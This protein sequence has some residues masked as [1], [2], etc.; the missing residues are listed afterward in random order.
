V[1]RLAV[2]GLI[3]IYL[4]GALGLQLQMQFCCGHL[5]AVNL[6]PEA[7]CTKDSACCNHQQCCS[8]ILIDS[9]VDEAHF[10]S[11]FSVSVDNH[12]LPISKTGVQRVVHG[13]G[14]TIHLSARSYN[15]PPPKT[16]AQLLALH[17]DWQFD[18]EC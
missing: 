18:S 9:E 1:K 6:T 5:T 11:I 14:L 2:I 4:L 3:S 10:A 16:S 7:N 13:N 8:S 12:F 15:K 17:Q